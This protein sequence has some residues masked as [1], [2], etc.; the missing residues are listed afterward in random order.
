MLAAGRSH[1]LGPDAGLDLADV[2]FAQQEH[3]QPAL[4]YAASDTLRKISREQPAVEIE[5][6]AV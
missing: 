5:L 2:A 6:F 4:P 3:A 1:G